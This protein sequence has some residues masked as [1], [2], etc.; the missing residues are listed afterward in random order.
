VKKKIG[1]NNFDWP[2]LLH[3]GGLATGIHQATFDYFPC[4]ANNILAHYHV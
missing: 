3:L 1:T 2:G 4:E